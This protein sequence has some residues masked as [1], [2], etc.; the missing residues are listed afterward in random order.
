MR[1]RPNSVLARGCGTHMHRGD[2]AVVDVTDKHAE[3][4]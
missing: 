4:L 2:R 3:F 1:N